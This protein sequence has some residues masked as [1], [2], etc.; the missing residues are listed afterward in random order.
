MSRGDAHA[1]AADLDVALLHDVEQA[2]L[3]ARLQTSGNSFD[4]EG[5]RGW[6]AE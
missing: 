3:D 6:S 1:E 2:H 5:C 4:D